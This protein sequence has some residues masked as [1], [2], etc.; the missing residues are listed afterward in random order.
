MTPKIAMHSANN[1]SA[2]LGIPTSPEIQTNTGLYIMN[3]IKLF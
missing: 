2:K 1:T 3:A